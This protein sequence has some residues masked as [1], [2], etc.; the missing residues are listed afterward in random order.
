GAAWKRHAAPAWLDG[1]ECV[2]FALPSGH[3]RVVVMGEGPPVVLL[4]PLPGYKEAWI[5][6]AAPLAR[7][8]RVVTFDLRARFAGPPRW[9]ALALARRLAAREAWVYDRHCDDQ[10]LDFVR[11]CIRD[12]S[13][14]VVSAALRLVRAHDVRARLP[15]IACPTLIVTGERETGFVRESAD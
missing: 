3:T 4:P 13:M 8:F 2:P 11:F 14:P 9:D 15:A 1:W 10:V 5:A 7:R 6:C 12:A